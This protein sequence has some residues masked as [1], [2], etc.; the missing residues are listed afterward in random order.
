MC[1]KG[2]TPYETRTWL[3]GDAPFEYFFFGSLEMFGEIVCCKR[4]EKSGECPFVLNSYEA[5]NGDATY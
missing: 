1:V 2:V 5:A 3:A 4:I